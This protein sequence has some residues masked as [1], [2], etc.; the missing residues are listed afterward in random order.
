MMMLMMMI[1]I[2]IVL[3][4]MSLLSIIVI[5][6]Y[7]KHIRCIFMYFLG[8]AF[9]SDFDIYRMDGDIFGF[10]MRLLHCSCFVS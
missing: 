4:M 1:I 6:P 2:I 8:V 10:V 9:C 3:M 5:V 7:E